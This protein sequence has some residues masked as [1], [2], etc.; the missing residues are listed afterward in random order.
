MKKIFFVFLLVLAAS[1]LNAGVTG[2]ADEVK[3]GAILSLSQ[4][5]S[6]GLPARRGIEIA[7]NEINSKG[8]IKG[9]KLYVVFEDS[10][11]SSQSAIAAFQ[12]LVSM[13]QVKVIIGP[14]TSGEVLDVTFDLDVLDKDRPVI[15]NVWL[16]GSGKLICKGEYY[17]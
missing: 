13:D 12:K 9:K 11:D 7:V 1:Y 2:A 3:I 17:L 6:L 5:V 14:M 4:S 10:K 16:K 8:G 15:T